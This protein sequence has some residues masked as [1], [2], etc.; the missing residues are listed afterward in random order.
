MG[1]TNFDTING[2]IIAET[3]GGQ[4]KN[5]VVDAFGSVTGV[6]QNGSISGAARYSPY[7]RTIAGSS[8]ATGGWVWSWGYYP[9]G[10]AFASHYVRARVFDNTTGAW[11]SMDPLWPYEAPFGYA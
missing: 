4:T 11:A 2:Q 8:G 1:V 7:G 3:S 6:S 9:T 5:Y 10:R